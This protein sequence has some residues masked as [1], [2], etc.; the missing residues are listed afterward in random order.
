MQVSSIRAIPR[1]LL[2]SLLVFGWGCGPDEEEQAQPDPQLAERLLEEAV[3][4]MSAGRYEQALAAYTEV[5]RLDSTHVP[6][7]HNM[8]IA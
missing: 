5:I 6:A 3:G 7:R 8:A 1:V 4:H 2:S